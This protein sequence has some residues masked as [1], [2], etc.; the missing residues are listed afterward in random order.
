MTSC[1]DF[2][3]HVLGYH[4]PLGHTLKSYM[5]DLLNGPGNNWKGNSLH[6]QELQGLRSCESQK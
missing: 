3:Q 4:M 2:C 5:L 6:G 1:F